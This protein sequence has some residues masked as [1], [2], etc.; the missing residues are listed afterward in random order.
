MCQWSSFGSHLELTPTRRHSCQWAERWAHNLQVTRVQP[1]SPTRVLRG[2][3]RHGCIPASRPDE[4][5]VAG[6]LGC[7]SDVFCVGRMC[8]GAIN[9]CKLM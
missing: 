4:R 2:A 5:D 6:V 3:A 1:Q 8:H 7:E 9:S